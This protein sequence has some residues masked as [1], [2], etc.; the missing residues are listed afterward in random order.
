MISPLEVL[1][2]VAEKKKLPLV[3]MRPVMQGA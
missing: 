2:A 1:E 3:L